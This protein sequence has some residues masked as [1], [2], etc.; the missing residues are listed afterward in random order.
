M[1]TAA[2]LQQ[3]IVSVDPPRPS[4]S[5]ANDAA[6]AKTTS[7]AFR[8]S[9]EGDLD[10][11]VLKALQKVHQRY[12]A[13]DSFASDIE[14]HLHGLTIKARPI[15]HLFGCRSSLIVTVLR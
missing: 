3:A 11:I 1:N 4:V 12:L 6:Y 9:L 2:E 8:R 13:I 14:R 10:S 5:I 15:H 7:K